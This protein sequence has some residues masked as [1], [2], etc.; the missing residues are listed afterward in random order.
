MDGYGQLMKNLII[1]NNDQHLEFL[2]SP[3]NHY[4]VLSVDD[5]LHID[6]THLKN[7]RIFNLC[8]DYSYC[9]KGYY[10][11][12]LAEARGHRPFPNISTLIEFQNKKSIRLLS[13]HFSDAMNENLKH[14]RGDDFELSVYF[15]KNMA[16]KYAAI[17]WQIFNT[18]QAPLIRVAYAKKSGEWRLRSIQ[19]ISLK[20]VP[21]GHK[22]FLKQ[23]MD[24]FFDSKKGLS[25]KRSRTAK[26]DLAILVNPDEDQAPSDERTLR[27]FVRAAQ[28]LR[29][30]AELIEPKDISLIN[31][32]DALF[33]R[34]TT[35]V[36]HHT[37]KFAK[38]A[39]DQGLVVID[40]PTSIIRCC[41]KVYLNDHLQKRKLSTPKT[42][43]LSKSSDLKSVGLSFPIVVK[44]P[45]SAFSAGVKKAKDHDELEQVLQDFFKTS[46]LV[47]LQEYI[48]T[49][50]DWRVGLIDGE[51]LYVCKYFMANNHWQIIKQEKGRM[52]EGNVDTY[53]L[54]ETPRQVIRLAQKACETIGNSLYGVDI[55][56]SDGNFY[57]IEINDNP[58]IEKGYEDRV[59][60]D[61]LYLRIMS[62]FLRRLETR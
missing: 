43:I 38:T 41:N 59:A 57:V 52:S 53:A 14:I 15:G 46:D 35:S 45:D 44:K 17:A 26:Y 39:E 25:S 37:Y 22:D 5:Y 24:V 21:A 19:P 42:V 13:S 7:A 20:D 6:Q 56:E 62:S 11:S 33:I 23:S 12:L 32:F 2:S 60:G 34:E 47:I 18:V 30:S 8:S 16:E 58:S 51:P 55:K 4:E 49:D 10:V 54:S 29:I 1:V 48:K 27:A 31:R 61:A 9:K 3:S 28:D 36:L 40:D 50:F